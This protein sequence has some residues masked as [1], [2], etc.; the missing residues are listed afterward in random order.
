MMPPEKPKP[1]RAD[2]EETTRERFEEVRHQLANALDY[3]G[4][5]DTERMLVA[6]DKAKG[7]AEKLKT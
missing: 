5:R 1:T 7:L 3:C 6:I 4:A 2:I